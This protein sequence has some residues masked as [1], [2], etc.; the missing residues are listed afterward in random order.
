MGEKP[1]TGKTTIV[2]AQDSGIGNR[3]Q[4]MA[5]AIRI[6]DIKDFDLYWP[7]EGWVSAAFS[8]L[9]DFEWDYEVREHNE[10][11]M[12]RNLPEEAPLCYTKG[13]RL[14]I[15]PE[16]GLSRFFPWLYDNAEHG[17]SI[18]FEYN[19]IPGRIRDIYRPFF[20]RLNP[21]KAVLEKVN[22][23]V[24]PE[25]TV[26]LQVRNNPDWQQHNRTVALDEY[27]RLMDKYP[28][29]TK[30]FLCAMNKETENAF[31]ERYGSRIIVQKDK[32]FHS[33]I[34]AAADLFLMAKCS[35]MI[36]SFESSFGCL[37]WWLGGAAANVRV[38]GGSGLFKCVKR[39]FLNVC[40]FLFVKN[41]KNR[42][43]E[44]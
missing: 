28:E 34:D 13:W 4:F 29:K 14:Y 10:L 38:A 40:R 25:N 24:L 37:A 43:F 15:S 5:S 7:V 27:F 16:D 42:L 2:L 44:R 32:D 21:S 11:V 18:D 30:F 35:E 36:L 23:V 39:K 20:K 8:D 17:Y 19:R 33:M 12:L 9:F 6:Y 3:I 1:R 22:A 26:A 41:C 31:V